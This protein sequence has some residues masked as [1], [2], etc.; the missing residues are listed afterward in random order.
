MGEEVVEL[1]LLG[2]LDALR[3][4]D[5]GLVGLDL[6]AKQNLKVPTNFD[7]FLTAAKALTDDRGGLT[8]DHGVA[9]LPSNDPYRPG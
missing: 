3:L 4:L 5:V 2:M 9:W 7:E 8:F 6:L 1:L